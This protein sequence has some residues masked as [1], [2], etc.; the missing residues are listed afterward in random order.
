[1]NSD[2]FHGDCFDV[3]MM[4][5]LPGI[6]KHMDHLPGL[7]DGVVSI[8]L[9]PAFNAGPDGRFPADHGFFFN[10]SCECTADNTL[11]NKFIAFFQFSFGIPL[12]HSGAGSGTT[13]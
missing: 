3:V 1:M 10:S 6:H 9:C 13:R 4:I 2:F 12:G 11:M 5:I 7:S 8:N